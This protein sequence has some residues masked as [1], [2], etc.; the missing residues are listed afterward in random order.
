MFSNSY[1]YTKFI[2]SP[3]DLGISSD[4]NV[5]TLSNDI[6][7]LMAYVELLIAGSGKA[8]KTGQPLGNK[9]FFNTGTQCKNME[10]NENVDRYIYI[11]NIPDGKIPFIETD[12]TELRGLVPGILSNIENLNLTDPVSVFEAF[13][14]DGGLPCQQITLETVDTDNN[15][16]Q[17][18]QYISTLDIQ[19][20]DPCLFPNKTNPVTNQGCQESFESMCLLPQDIISQAFLL[21]FGLLV[22]FLLFGMIKKLSF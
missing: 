7:G 12:F 9:F 14:K 5:K 20:M 21:T 3:S 18:T 15:V 2:N 19:N 17:E 13:K 10:T 16:S 1:S 22:I 6:T 4:G 11:N 8:S